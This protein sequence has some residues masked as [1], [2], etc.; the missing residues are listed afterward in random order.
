MTTDNDTHPAYLLALRQSRYALVAGFK[1]N[2]KAKWWVQDIGTWRTLVFWMR[3]APKLMGFRSLNDWTKQSRS[4]HLLATSCILYLAELL[5]TDSLR[6]KCSFISNAVRCKLLPT[7]ICP[8]WFLSHRTRVPYN[9]GCHRESSGACAAVAGVVVVLAESEIVD[10]SN[11]FDKLPAPA[12]ECTSTLIF[13]TLAPWQPFYGTFRF[14]SPP[15]TFH[16]TVP[17]LRFTAILAPRLS[18][19]HPYYQ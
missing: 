14:F 3:L 15:F 7:Q 1:P 8:S 17:R 4:N 5:A 18:N 10:R 11:E 9:V 2:P 16:L 19:L 6:M 13:P 12:C